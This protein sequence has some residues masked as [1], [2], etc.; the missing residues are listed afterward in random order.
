LERLQWSRTDWPRPVLRVIGAGLLISTGAIHLDLYLTGYSS[1]PEIGWLFLLQAISACGLGLVVLVSGSRLAALSGALLALST[2][3][4]YLL[5]LRIGLFGFREVRT[6]A[7]I[8]AGV[9]EVAAFAGLAA[10]VLDARGRLRLTAV[11]PR[12]SELVARLQAGIPSA[13]WAVAAMSVLAVVLL[14]ISLASKGPTSTG[15]GAPVALLR[16]AKVGGVSV[17]ANARGFTL[18]WF[19]PDTPLK[20]KCYGTCAA[21]WPPVIGTPVAGRDVTGK[22][23]TIRRSDGAVQVTYDRHPLYTYIGDGAPGQAA[24]NNIDLNGGLWHEMA[25][26]G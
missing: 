13:R 19:G 9:V 4:G 1:L 2:L 10:F 23:G 22:L 11:T 14:G 24:G 25:V 5:S 17:L 8:V 16:I 6:T 7:G 3:G 20:S 18:Y 12:T 15:T 21:Y 26:S